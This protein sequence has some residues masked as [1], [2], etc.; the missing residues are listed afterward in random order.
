VALGFT[1]ALGA[2]PILLTVYVVYAFA[3]RFAVV[4]GTGAVDSLRRAWDFLHGRV[5]ES[6]KLLVLAF[7]G[8]VGGAMAAFAAATPGIVAG[9][10]AWL[11]TGEV[12]L[13]VAVGSVI[14][15]PPVLVVAGA[16]GTFRSSVWTMGFLESR[17]AA[18][19]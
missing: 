18:R 15:L 12:W 4:D 17:E 14:V 1:V 6:V 8:Q 7:L 9:V 11:V 19:A 10:V 5:L 2:A 16:A 3:L 13:G